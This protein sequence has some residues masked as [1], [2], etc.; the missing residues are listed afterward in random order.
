[1]VF[2]DESDILVSVRIRV[3]LVGR[4]VVQVQYACRRYKAGR[5]SVDGVMPWRDARRSD[6]VEVARWFE[7]VEQ[8][9]GQ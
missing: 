3:G 1:M 9:A 2:R 7:R 8:G 5:M 6:T 4:P